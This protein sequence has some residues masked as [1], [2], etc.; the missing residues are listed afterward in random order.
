MITVS[1]SNPRD[2]KDREAMESG[3]AMGALREERLEALLEY[4]A[5]IVDVELPEDE[6]EDNE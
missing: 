1:M 6:E 5:M 4:T 3:L 2:V